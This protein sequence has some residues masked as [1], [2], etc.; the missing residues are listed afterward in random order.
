MR[1][2]AREGDFIET[3]EGLMFDVKGL[4]HPPN[5]IIAFLRYFPDE[6]GERKRNS[7]RYSKVYSLSKRYALL[8]NRFPQYLVY[9]PVFDVT[10]CEVP[11]DAVKKHYKPTQKLQ[12]LRSS[13]SPD[14]L[15]NLAL[16]LTK[17]MKENANIPWN[18]IGISGSIMARLHKPSSD[19]DVIV[20]G[21]KN[22]RKVYTTMENLLGEKQ[23]PFKPYTREGL[24]ALFDFRSKDTVVGF[25]DF[26]RSE[27]RKVLQGKFMGTDYF[28]RFVKDWSEIDEKYGD[29]QYVNVGYA[30]I[31]ATVADDSES[32]FTPCVYKIDDVHVFEGNSFPVTEIASFRGRFCEQARNGEVVIAQGKVEHV[33]DNKRNREHFRLLLGNKPSDY[34]VTVPKP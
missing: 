2:K 17:V 13:S 19:I 32:I 9:N 15:E 22:C 26:V 25:E 1:F 30:R 6:K 31:K 3:S 14:K 28:I 34:F 23:G 7:E 21:S 12:E 4:I 20:Y 5:R 24:K 16:Q 33:I 29:V 27:S 10:L 8:K 18:T 11:V